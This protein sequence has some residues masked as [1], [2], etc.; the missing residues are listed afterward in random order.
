MRV[1]VRVRD[2]VPAGTGL[3][4]VGPGILSSPIRSKKH[5]VRSNVTLFVVTPMLETLNTEHIN[6]VT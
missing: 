1:R 5:A 2:T 6:A 4:N 3:G